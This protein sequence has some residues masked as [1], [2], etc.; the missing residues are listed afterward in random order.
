MELRMTRTVSAALA[1]ALTTCAP[2]PPANEG[3]RPDVELVGRV[4]GA[5]KRCVS[6]SSIQTLR[7]SDSD[8]HLLLYGN[9]P[10]IWANALGP[11]CSFGR[12]EILVTEPTG[13]SYCRGDVVRSIDRISHFPGPTCVF[14]DFIP[15]RRP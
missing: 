4:A 11:N 5:P 10:T 12:D 3:Q 7:I 13:S 15:Y 6:I 9:G 2:L 1:L 8:P 14:G